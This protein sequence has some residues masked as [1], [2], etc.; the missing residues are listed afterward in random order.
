MSTLLGNG[1]ITFGDG[2][3]HITE[4][5]K[6][7]SAFTNDGVYLTPSDVA[8]TYA[9]KTQTVGSFAIVQLGYSMTLYLDDINGNHIGGGFF[10][11]NCN[12]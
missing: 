12:C 7:L 11:C 2:T 9:A 1:N 5:Q 6:N 10:N 8:A 4:T 3:V